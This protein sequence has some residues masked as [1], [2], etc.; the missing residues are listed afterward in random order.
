MCALSLCLWY[1]LI[2]ALNLAV[3]HHSVV[4]EKGYKAGY[5]TGIA[6]T[7]SI[8]NMLQDYL[9]RRPSLNGRALAVLRTQGVGPKE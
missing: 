4:Y 3:W 6:D 5:K 9:A 7:L 1:L 2:L 8:E